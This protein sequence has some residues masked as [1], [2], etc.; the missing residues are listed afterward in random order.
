MT[1]SAL[2][3]AAVLFGIVSVYLSVR[4]NIWSWP[5]AIVNVTLYIFV[6]F[7]ARLYADMALQFVYIGISVYGWYEWLHGGRGK[8]E[9]AVSRGTRRLAIILVGI[10]ILATGLI[11]AVLSR[12]TNAALPWLDSMTTATSLIAQ[13][14]MARKILE[15]WIVW[16]A[17]DV[18]YIGMFLYKS[19]FLT[20]LLYAVF[21]VL[22]V[23]GYFRWKRSLPPPQRLGGSGR[24]HR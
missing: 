14:M 11:G 1:F 5:T 22:S 6:F 8:G 23:T 4:E 10:G 7:R 24:T 12:Y 15:N 16:V 21:L 19:L 18:V 2:E 17:V 9:L 3:I 13:W 20:A